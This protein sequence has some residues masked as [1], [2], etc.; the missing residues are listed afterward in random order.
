MKR[1]KKNIK[2]IIII[3]EIISITQMADSERF[4]EELLHNVINK[5]KKK[6]L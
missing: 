3:S 1:I 5:I 2:K 4:L 6:Q